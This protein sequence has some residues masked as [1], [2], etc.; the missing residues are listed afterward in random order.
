MHGAKCLK[1][2]ILIHSYTLVLFAESPN[3][4]GKKEAAIS[5]S[6]RRMT[7]TA[8]RTEAPCGSCS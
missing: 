4:L 7:M 2:M 6:G 8:E 5:P 3:R 1:N